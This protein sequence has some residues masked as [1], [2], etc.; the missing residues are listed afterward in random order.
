MSAAAVEHPC[1]G[2]ERTLLDDAERISALLPGHRVEI[3]G[4]Q[5]TVTPPA[6]M[7]HADSLSDLMLPFF[8][9]GVHGEQTRVVQSGGVWLPD[10]PYDYAI[11]DLAVVDADYRDHLI[12]ANCYDPAVFRLVLE[13]TSNNLANDLKAKVAAYAIAKIP[14]YVIV[15][16]AKERIHVLTDPFANEYNH[17]RVY[18]AGERVTLPDS[19]GAE[20]TLDVAAILATGRH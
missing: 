6:D 18:A 7:P 4:G 9:A 11:P 17:H 14:V 5:I 3:I 8:A 20:V 13:V 15:N 1:A 10:G 19:I 2:P 16:R 12:R